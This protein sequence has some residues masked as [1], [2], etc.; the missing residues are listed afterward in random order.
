MRKTKIASVITDIIPVLAVA[1][2]ACVIYA[3]LLGILPVYPEVFALAGGAAIEL[4]GFRAMSLSTEMR[5]FNAA[6]KN[7]DERSQFGAPVKQAYYLV[8]AYLAVTVTIA[9][10]L[11][12]HPIAAL[13]PFLGLSGGWLNGLQTGQR[14]RKADRDKMRDEKKAESEKPREEKNAAK[15][16][17]LG[18]KSGKVVTKPSRKLPVPT[19]KLLTTWQQ[20]PQASNKVVGDLVGLSAE[21]VRLRKKNLIENGVIRV[22]GHGVEIIEGK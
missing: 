21:A 13:F 1:P 19:T 18:S 8:V 17:Q 10:V 6:N 22:N 20:A 12:A 5:A 16:Q 14:K 2:T 4:I 15:S 9:L 7:K 3:G 11:D